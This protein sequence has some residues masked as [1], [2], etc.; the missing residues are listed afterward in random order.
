MHMSERFGKRIICLA[1]SRKLAGRCVAGKEIDKP[2]RWIRPVSS[3]I[4]GAL[5][6][7]DISFSPPHVLR[8]LDIV[9][10]SMLE[11]KPQSYQ[12][13]NYIID[14]DHHWIFF[15]KALFN[16]VLAL[17]DQFSAPLWHNG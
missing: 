1:N 14:Q 4:T 8:P 12:S 16:D 7:G 13:E 17:V 2:H 3:K 9:Q 5:S 15:G 6:E 11:A 10:I